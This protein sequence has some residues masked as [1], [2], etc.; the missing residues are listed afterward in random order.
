M[1]GVNS[2]PSI[3]LGIRH[4]FKFSRYMHLNLYYK[5][6]S[7]YSQHTYISGVQFMLVSQTLVSGSSIVQ[8][9]L[10][11]FRNCR[12]Q[13]SCFSVTWF[14]HPPQLSVNHRQWRVPQQ[15]IMITYNSKWSILIQKIR[16]I[17]SGDNLT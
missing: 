6:F 16:I 14:S 13:W 10:H 9:W 7:A 5:L 3:L 2:F 17:L 15:S 8:V 12:T 4:H 1:F 11:G